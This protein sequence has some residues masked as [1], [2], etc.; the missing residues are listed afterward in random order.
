MT[1]QKT[2]VMPFDT[3]PSFPSNLSPDQD[4]AMGMRW[5]NSI[6]PFDRSWWLKEA[7]SAVP[8]DAWECYKSSLPEIIQ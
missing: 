3:F 2:T 8:A 5:W 6:S 1:S 7:G 4:A